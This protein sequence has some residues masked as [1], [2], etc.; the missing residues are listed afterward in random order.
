[1]CFEYPVV[2]THRSISLYGRLAETGGM[3]VGQREK[4]ATEAVENFYYHTAGLEEV[5]PSFGTSPRQGIQELHSYG[6]EGWLQGRFQGLRKWCMIVDLSFPEG[7]SVNEGIV[8]TYAHC[9]TRR[10]KRQPKSW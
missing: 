1:M 10:W 8:Q 3:R 5:E 9:T 2:L 4:L 6:V 7:G